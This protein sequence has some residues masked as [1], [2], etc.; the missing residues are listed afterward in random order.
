VI[1]QRQGEV[2]VRVGK[3]GKIAGHFF[4][5]Y[6]R[7]DNKMPNLLLALPF[8]A[9]LPKG[10]WGVLNIPWLHSW[11]AQYFEFTPLAALI[12]NI[13]ATL[14]LIN[15]ALRVLRYFLYPSGH[16]ERTSLI[17]RVINLVINPFSPLIRKAFDYLQGRAREKRMQQVKVSTELMEGAGLLH[18][19]KAVFAGVTSSFNTIVNIIDSVKVI[20]PFYI[21]EDKLLRAIWGKPSAEL[22]RDKDFIKCFRATI[23]KMLLEKIPPKRIIAV[24]PRLWPVIS[25]LPMHA[26]NVARLF[27][28]LL[29]QTKLDEPQAQS[30]IRETLLNNLILTDAQLEII[31]GIVINEKL[32][33]QAR[34]QQ[35]VARLLEDGWQENLEHPKRELARR[36]IA[37][38]VNDA[39]FAREYG[40]RVILLG[41]ISLFSQDEKFREMFVNNIAFGFVSR[42]LNSDKF[43]EEHAGQ[44]TELFHDAVSHFDVI[45]RLS[46]EELGFA[47]GQNPQELIN[48]PEWLANFLIEEGNFLTV[49]DR[50]SEHLNFRMVNFISNEIS[51]SINEL[52]ELRAQS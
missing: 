34:Q 17:L 44:I 25:R 23:L 24:C 15:I 48:N 20:D 9:M 43:R 42:I 45:S 8:T 47:L 51:Q 6:I 39:G 36:L 49:L 33:R 10:D 13:V 7:L 16:R 41:I 30:C 18:S 14:L 35:I 3:G 1:Y 31:G 29:L 5:Y 2:L 38:T 50:Y 28:T 26:I 37:E 32:E 12:I 21:Y 27:I 52:S 11:L 4:D 46:D 19:M 22:F 40:Y